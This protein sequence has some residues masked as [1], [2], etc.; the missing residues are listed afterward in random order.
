MA[1]RCCRWL[2]EC[3]VRDTDHPIDAHVKRYLFPVALTVFGVTAYLLPR[4]IRETLLVY[5]M[6]DGLLLT[7]AVLFCIAMMINLGKARV[8]AD[9]FLCGVTL[10][11]ILL[12]LASA[13]LSRVRTWTI[14]VLVLD[15]SLV[16]GR[17]HLPPVVIPITLVYIVA[18]AAEAVLRYGMYDFGYWGTSV[19]ASF[20]NCVSPPCSMNFVEAAAATIPGVLIFL[21]DYYLTRGFASALRKQLNIAQM[22][23]QVAGK[24]A[25]S[26]AQYDIDA[27]ETAIREGHDLPPDLQDSY[28]QLLSNLR[29]YK[30]YLPHSCLVRHEPPTQ[31]RSAGSLDRELALQSPAGSDDA[32][33]S[34][35]ESR[36]ARNASMATVE[37]RRTSASSWVSGVSMLSE[38][39][40]PHH[41]LQVNLKAAQGNLKAAAKRTRVS[42]AA[43]NRVGYLPPQGAELGELSGHSNAEWIANDVES[44]CIKVAQ[45]RGVVDVMGGD[46]RFASFNARQACGDHAGAAV[47]VLNSRGEGASIAW[48]GCVVTGHAVCGDFGCPSAMRFMVLGRVSSSLHPFERVAAMWGIGVLADDHAYSSASVSWDGR[49][50]GAVFLTKR[51]PGAIRVYDIT[52][53]RPERENK[54]GH[55]EWMYELAKM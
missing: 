28:L 53:K 29:E 21:M 3:T 33:D 30:A 4:Y 46:R 52:S 44:W 40:E 37:R 35:T 12:D 50:L 34:D 9:L 8:H 43:G 17:D 32:L 51:D 22:S 24:I 19:E 11:V 15:A 38:L 42:L 6:A 18:E 41:Q 14:I 10:G 54:T 39:S 13:T 16:F 36:A 45:V 55:V 49:L 27:A 20:C 26:L 23:V 47:T 2:S 5:L 25:A 48:T 7:A 31:R 1:L